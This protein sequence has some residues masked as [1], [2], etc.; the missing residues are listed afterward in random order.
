M[1]SKRFIFNLFWVVFAVT[2][3][4]EVLYN[5]GDVNF[6]DYLPTLDPSIE[7]LVHLE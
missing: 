1:T 2:L 6:V 3:W 4:M 5:Y 7:Q